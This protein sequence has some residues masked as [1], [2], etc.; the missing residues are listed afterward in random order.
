LGKI[1]HL[2]NT[3]KMSADGPIID[4]YTETLRFVRGFYRQMDPDIAGL[5]SWLLK[6]RFQPKRSYT[7]SNDRIVFYYFIPDDPSVTPLSP[8]DLSLALTKYFPGLGLVVMRTGFSNQ[9]DTFSYFFSSSFWRDSHQDF[10]RNSFVIEKRGPL[11]LNTGSGGHSQYGSATLSSNN[12]IFLPAGWQNSNE[13]GSQKGGYRQI[14]DLEDIV[15]TSQDRSR[16]YYVGGVTKIAGNQDFDYVL[17]DA[18][19]A[20][21]PYASF[22]QRSFVYLRPKNIDES[23]YFVV[24]DRTE[25]TDLAGETRWLLHSGFQPAIGGQEVLIDQNVSRYE[26]FTGL[27]TIDNSNPYYPEASGRLFGK[28]ILP[29][30]SEIYLIKPPLTSGNAQRTA[31]LPTSHKNIE[32]VTEEEAF[33]KGRYRLEV[34]PTEAKTDHHFLTVFQTAKASQP[35]MTEVYEVNANTMLGVFIND[36]AIPR[37]ILFSKDQQGSSVSSVTYTAGYSANLSGRHLLADMEPGTYDIYKN[38]VEI[39]SDV[40]VSGQ[41][42]LYF[43][44]FGGS[45]FEIIPTGTTSLKGD[46]TGDN[47]V[48]IQDLQA[49]VNV[50]LGTET[51]PGFIQ[52]AKEVA[53]PKDECNVLDVQAIVNIILTP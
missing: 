39:F 16:Q 14:Y 27:I 51:D 3:F 20:A 11:A 42:I 19:A 26:N 18:G 47:Q 4:V 43:E 2:A 12:I 1:Y 36:P 32:I 22:Y 13:Q 9:N 45:T 44:A 5:S 40:P 25:R 48:N 6:N 38:G 31:N 52:R 29:G 17:G 21:Y 34:I 46:L 7:K 24:F 8:N 49:C 50:F 37:V 30:K 41:G 28:I 23:D 10:L 15:K 35:S 53:E 33:Y